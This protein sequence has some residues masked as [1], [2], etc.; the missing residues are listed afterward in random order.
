ME[1]QWN[2]CGSH[3]D[4]GHCNEFSCCLLCM[5]PVHTP[6]FRFLMHADRRHPPHICSCNCIQMHLLGHHR[7]TGNG[8][9]S[10]DRQETN[11]QNLPRN[12]RSKNR[13]RKPPEISREISSPTTQR[14]GSCHHGTRCRPPRLRSC[15]GSRRSEWVR[16]AADGSMGGG[17]QRW[18]MGSPDVVKRCW[19]MLGV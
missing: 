5:F 18:R 15:S 12:L 14:V 1:E 17:S 13:H 11:L 19:E 7:L 2:N 6:F 9:I 10:R 3:G 16:T 8:L 4:H